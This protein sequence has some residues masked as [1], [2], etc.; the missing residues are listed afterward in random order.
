[1]GKNQ[2]LRTNQSGMVAITITIILMVVISLIVIGFSTTIRREQRQALDAQLSSQ[3]FYA[4][5]SGVNLAISKLQDDATISKSTCA[6]GSGISNSDYQIDGDNVRITC[7]LINPKV[8]A[9]IHQNLSM[10]SRVSRISADHPISKIRITWKRAGA[11]GANC[12]GT[13][14]FPTRPTWTASSGCDQ[15]LL[16]VDMVSLGNDP[17]SLTASGLKESQFTAFLSP[18][19]GIPVPLYEYEDAQAPNNLGRVLSG[20]CATECSVEIDPNAVT[21][22][23]GGLFGSHRNYAIR[24]MSL[25][26]NSSEVKIEVFQASGTLQDM[27]GAQA[28][29]DS[30]ARAQDVLKR[31]QV[32]VNLAGFGSGYVP[33]FAVDSRSGICKRYT[34][35]GVTPD[36]AT[37]LPPECA[38]P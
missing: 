22:G 6:P 27:F 30:T 36:V 37:G 18:R 34:T 1:M 23:T 3:A 16:R 33:D 9:I 5:E 7:L 2:N 28:V 17:N 10:N 32:R 8:N 13:T 25:Y 24:L 38:A 12:T 19:Q 29:I 35:N 26:R 15:P 21:P 20:A 11:S 4:A 31:V 14:V